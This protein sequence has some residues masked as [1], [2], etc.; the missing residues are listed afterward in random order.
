MEMYVT[1]YCINSIVK[2]QSCQNMLCTE[3]VRCT[4][5][6]YPAIYLAQQVGGIQHALRHFAQ[7]QAF[8]HGG[9]AQ[10][11]VRDLL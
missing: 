7:A 2:I 3:F 6:G 5:K 8:V 1:S 9:L 10:L 11:V 4:N